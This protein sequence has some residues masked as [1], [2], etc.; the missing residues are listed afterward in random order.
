MPIDS[1]IRCVKM[2]ENASLVL[3]ATILFEKILVFNLY[4]VHSVEALSR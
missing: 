4:D 3:L 1:I 2:G